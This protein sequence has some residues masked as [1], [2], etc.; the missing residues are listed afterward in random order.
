M[1]RVSTSERFGS[2]ISLG[3][4][5]NTEAGEAAPTLSPD[6]R[7]LL[8]ASDREIDDP[9]SYPSGTGWRLYM[10]TRESAYGPFGTPE[11]LYIRTPGSEATVADAGPSISPDGST[12]YFS[13]EI[14]I[15]DT[16]IWEVPILQGPWAR[17]RGPTRGRGERSGRLAAWVLLL[18]CRLGSGCAAPSVRSG[19]QPWQLP[20]QPCPTSQDQALVS[21]HSAGKG[22]Q[23]RREGSPALTVRDVSIGGGRRQA[24]TFWC[25]PE[26][27]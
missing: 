15:P 8:F 5:I 12:L 7:T 13:R 16:N 6:G 2:P 23:D 10:A 27:N 1:K 17:A 14:V 11:P 19:I 21:Y 3:P 9:N 24:R 26:E 22:D 4:A 18:R 25:D 20:S